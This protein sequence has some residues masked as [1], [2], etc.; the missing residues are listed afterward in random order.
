MAARASPASAAQVA[1]NGAV[2]AV[3]RAEMERRKWKPGDFNKV[4]GKPAGHTAIYQWLA[5]KG[6]PGP[7]LAAKVAKVLGL[8]VAQLTP[9]GGEGRQVVVAPREA[10]EVVVA[11]Q[12]RAAEVLAFHVLDDG[13]ARIRLDVTLPLELAKPLLRM[14]L[15]AGVVFGDRDATA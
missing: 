14:V 13:Q 8:S 7:T 11:P 3:L 12:R 5:A 2:A 9:G 10:G 4:I 15:D 6:A 1:R